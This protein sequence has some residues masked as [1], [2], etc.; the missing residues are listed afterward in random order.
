[1]YYSQYRE[2]YDQLFKMDSSNIESVYTNGGYLNDYSTIENMTDGS[3]DIYW[4]SAKQNSD[5]YKNEIIFTLKEVTVLNRMAY[6]SAWN[7]VE[8]K[9]EPTKFKRKYS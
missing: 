5:T 4:E 7:T 6:R 8:F 3:L 1:M 2:A 9:F